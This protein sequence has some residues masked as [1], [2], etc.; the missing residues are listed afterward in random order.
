MD[1]ILLPRLI[2]STAAITYPCRSWRSNSG[3]GQWRGVPGN[4]LLAFGLP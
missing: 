2:A 4:V 1:V 3:Y